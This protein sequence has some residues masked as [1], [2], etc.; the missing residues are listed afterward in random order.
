MDKL[1]ILTPWYT[2]AYKAG[3]P[4]QSCIRLVQNLKLIYQV[5]IITGG[6][7]LHELKP[8]S[9]IELNRVQN[10]DK[11]VTIKYLSKDQYGVRTM[12][13]EITAYDPDYIYI[14]GMFSKPFAIDI[15]LAHRKLRHRSKLI[16][17]VHGACKPSALKHKRIKKAIFLAIVKL[18]GI[19]R[20]IIFHASSAEEMNE[21]RRVFGN[22]GIVVIDAFPPEHNK[23]F[24]PLKKQ[25]GNLDLILVGRIHPIKNIHFILQS[26]VTV[27]A[28]INL[29]IIGVK[30]D[31]IYFARCKKLISELPEH[32]RVK[33]A[34][35]MPNNQINAALSDAHLFV[36][37]TLGENYGYAII[38]A[39]SAG[40]P[41]LISDQTPWKNLE[42]NK[43]GWELPLSDPQKW[44]DVLNEAAAWDQDTFDSWCFGALD[45]AQKNT[46]TGELVAKYEQLFSN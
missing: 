42:T 9:G 43:G 5:H 35:E 32:I 1:L 4:I 44:I 36:L 15:I 28:K 20:S 23:L 12:K 33:I 31:E 25:P 18:L 10:L 37:P 39:L 13:R 38:E 46:R 6:Y 7:D 26:L 22:V 30:D 24:I 11:G 14:N 45:Y 17:T 34:G 27:K 8:L 19:H 41:A 3:G 40:R 21:I 2:P 16:L 29:C